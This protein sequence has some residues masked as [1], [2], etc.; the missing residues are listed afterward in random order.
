MNYR[1]VVVA[2]ILA[3]VIIT[4]VIA[5]DESNE[6]SSKFRFSGEIIG[7]Y[8][9]GLAED[10][11]VIIISPP[12]PGIYDDNTNFGNG[13][14]NG[15]YTSVNLNL[16][17]NPFPFIDVYAKLLVRSRPGSPY[18]PLQIEAA[19]RDSFS[20]VL[21]NAYGR[22]NVLGA[23]VPDSPLGLFLKAGKYDTTPASFQNVTRFGAED[24]I[25]RLRTKNT[26]AFQLALAYELPSAEAVTFSFTTH[27]KLNEAISPLYD[28]DGSTS[29]HGEPS[30]SEK[31]DIPLHF[32]LAMKKLNTPL[33]PISAE[34]IYAYNA[35]NIFSGHNFGFSAGWEITIPGVDNL[36]IPFGIAAAMYEKNIDP[37]AKVAVDTKST[38]YYMTGT[39]HENDYNT[40]SFRRSLRAGAGLGIRFYPITDLET[41]LNLGYSWSQ[42]AHI[43]RDT[44]EL[45]SASVDLL[46]TYNERFFIGG[47][48]YLGTLTDA[49]WKT[50]KD[51]DLSYEN[52][53]THT[54]KLAEN[55][56]YEC[57]IGMMFNSAST[58]DND[59]THS[60]FLIGYNN[61][62]GLS[63]NNAIESIP[64]AQI[65]FRQPGS[66][67]LDQLFER[68]GVFA[69]LVISW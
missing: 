1:N 10:D 53:Y 16:L 58:E 50:S 69:K 49:E 31:Y 34:L 22:V 43:Y 66:G 41:Q 60:R 64:S 14:K 12:P 45:H 13:G 36:S 7:M 24:V 19:E 68:G 20:V 37:F 3:F 2:L 57:F 54:F 5:Q 61:N 67:A 44:L 39:L 18:I 33:G 48:L 52:G 65:K 56:G 8:T 9:Y 55:L 28:S 26:Y 47:G 4:P 15:F 21:D 23:F 32:A 29:K 6:K 25:S 40:V 46:V 27:Q 35:E 63:M 17:Y 51:T 62:K 59:R 11:Q 38:G 30:L 42:V